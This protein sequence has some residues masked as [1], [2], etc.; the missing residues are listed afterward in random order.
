MPSRRQLAFLLVTILAAGVAVIYAQAPKK[1]VIAYPMG[2]RKWTHVKSMVIFGKDH[3][4]FS[5]FEG[6]HNVYVNDIGWPS[7]QQGRAYP[8]GSMFVFELFALKSSPGAIESGQR[9]FLAVMR[10]NA[11]LY[12]DTGGWGFEVFQGYQSTGSLKD[13]RPCFDCHASRKGRDYIFSDY[14]E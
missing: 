11:K 1:S 4:L 9:K 3:K 12:P 8:D 5:Q 7:F 2:H 14:S 6:L 10:K 13:M